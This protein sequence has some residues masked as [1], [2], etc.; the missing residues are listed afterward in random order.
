MRLRT[1]LWGG[2]DLL[3]HLVPIKSGVPNCVYLDE[4]LH[5]YR[6]SCVALAVKLRNL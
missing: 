6:T 4:T 1:F 5:Y 2:W 3:R